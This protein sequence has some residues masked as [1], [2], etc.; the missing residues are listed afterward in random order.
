M[1]QKA[2]VDILSDM[3][4]VDMLKDCIRDNYP[5]GISESILEPLITRYDIRLSKMLK[6]FVLRLVILLN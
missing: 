1:R 6:T 3:M 4:Q 2:S 5:D